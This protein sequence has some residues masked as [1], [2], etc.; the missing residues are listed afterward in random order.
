MNKNGK[1][2]L[3]FALSMAVGLGLGVTEDS[4]RW[5]LQKDPVKVQA[6]EADENGFVIEDGVLTGY[7]GEG[8]DVKIPDGVISIGDFAF[9]KCSNLSIVEIPG[10]VTF[11][12]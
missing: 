5:G 10:S 12:I 6:A 11:V 7:K 2:M 1:R 3:S 8:G 4:T 9:Y